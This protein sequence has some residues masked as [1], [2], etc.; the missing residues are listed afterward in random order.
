MWLDPNATDHRGLSRARIDATEAK[1]PQA[2]HAQLPK[3]EARIRQLREGFHLN[4]EGPNAMLT[5]YVVCI[6]IGWIPNL[7]QGLLPQPDERAP[8]RHRLPNSKGRPTGCNRLRRGP[9]PR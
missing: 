7:N 5:L 8:P 2:Y 1:E 3:W 4:C 9:A 6:A